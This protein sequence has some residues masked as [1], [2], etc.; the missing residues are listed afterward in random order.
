MPAA[1]AA[2]GRPRAGS[3][4]LYRGRPA[5]VTQ[6]DDKLEIELDGS[7][8]R[9]VRHKDVTLLHPGP[10]QSLGELT[11]REGEVEAAR[12]LL[13]GQSTTLAELAEL[14]FGEFTPASAWAAWQ[15]VADGL[16]FRGT[17]EA[18]SAR[19][20]EEVAA[21]REARA[22]RAAEARA[23]SAFLERVR[24][25]RVLP[26]DA[27]W[28][29]E[30]EAVAR[31]QKAASRVLKALG[32]QETPESAH[33]LLLSI[34]HWDESVNPHPARLRVPVDPPQVSVAALADEQRLDLTALDAFA[35][36]DE[37]NTDPDDAVSLDGE[38]VWVHVADAAA[39]APPDTPADL[40]ARG[41]GATLYLPE[42][43]A[44]M[45]P[46]GAVETLGLGLD[47]VS[48]ALSFGFQVS[49][50]GEVS[51]TEVTPSWVRVT[52]LTYAEAQARLTDP[53]FAELARR[54]QIFRARRRAQGATPIELPEVKVR[55]RRGEVCV[56]PLPRLE[57]R[58]LVTELMLMAGEAVAR[59]GL[60][61]DVALPFTTQKA[62]EGAKTPTTLSEMF[63][64]RRRLR[65][66]EMKTAPEPHA[67]LGLERYAQA[68]SPLRRY[69]DLIVHQ[70]LR[71][72]LAG[73]ETLAPDAILSRIGA[74]QAAT[75]Q[76][77]RAERLSNRH[78]TLVYL[79]RRPN[80][81]G[82]GVVV[83][84]R[85]RRAVVLI[86]ELA[87]DAEVYPPG[88]AAPDS[89]LQLSLKGVAL[90]ALSVS[91]EASR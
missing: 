20:P 82:R 49:E 69:L 79:Q 19:T 58:A 5:R 77:R 44:P 67:G 73:R 76:T 37:D 23:W 80:W 39:L 28:L 56:H 88:D 29:V 24:E 55:V 71:A 2:Q 62:P 17:P 89:E 12:D 52:R 43:T 90:P 18:L 54:A 74:A 60:S 72:H 6:A 15:V 64:Y 66:S 26:E 78:W 36:D 13:A 11:P 1:P 10:V 68:T 63:A 70:Q 53:P 59:F 50:Q 38:R 46:P 47:T 34:G 4:V 65:P 3:L 33:A 42:R 75:G 9:R 81:R 32:R 30:V 84:R 35:I 14:A 25:R 22:A 87:L 21:E 40:E 27:P 85:G 8:S 57:S 7:E 41:R 91:L 16:H 51:G 48:P 31:G 83:E 86:P 45:L 61:R